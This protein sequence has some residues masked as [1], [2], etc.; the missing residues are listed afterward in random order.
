MKVTPNECNLSIH[1]DNL[2]SP[3]KITMVMTKRFV[4]SI[5]FD[6]VVAFVE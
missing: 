2:S 5:I 3:M 4:T 6:V 1:N